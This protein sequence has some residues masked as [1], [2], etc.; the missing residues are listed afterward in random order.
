MSKLSGVNSFKVWKASLKDAEI[1][2]FE[3][4]GA[5]YYAYSQIFL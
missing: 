3:L 1:G 5:L 2:L 4:S